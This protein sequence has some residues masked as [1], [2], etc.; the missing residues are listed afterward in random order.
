MTYGDLASISAKIAGALVERGSAPGKIVGLFMPRGADLLIAQAGIT[1]SGAA[2][3]PFDAETPMD[4]VKVCVESANAIGLVTC[5]EWLPKFSNFP[6]PVW[7]L[8]D[9][10]AQNSAA[11]SAPQPNHPT[12]PT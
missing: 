6:V 3:L 10:L 12:R 8:E 5:R 11:E 1:T 2:W 9:L 7:A 4:R